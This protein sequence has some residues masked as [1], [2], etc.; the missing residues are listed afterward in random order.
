M[1]C[2][3]GGSPELCAPSAQSA[4][5]SGCCNF[6]CLAGSLPQTQGKA[7]ALH[8][9]QLLGCIWQGCNVHQCRVCGEQT[10]DCCSCGGV[11]KCLS[12]TDPTSASQCPPKVDWLLQLLGLYLAGGLAGSISHVLWY[13]WKARN[14][15]RSPWGGPSWAAQSPAALGA[16]GAVNAIVVGD[17]ADDLCVSYALLPLSQPGWVALPPHCTDTAGASSLPLPGL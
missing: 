3:G 9:L 8:A 14:L 7:H 12:H 15:P 17:G 10:S 1:L 2:W 16:S 4:M 11:A 13:W 5:S 6:V